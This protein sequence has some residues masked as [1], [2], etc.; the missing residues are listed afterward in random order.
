MGRLSEALKYYVHDRLN[1]D[2]GWRG[3]EVILAMR[4]CRA[5]ASTRRCI[6]FVNS[7]DCR[8]GIRTRDTS[9]TVW[10]RI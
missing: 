10:T 1:N 7:E 9:C 3:I 2:P 8:D 6:T 5:R 4:A